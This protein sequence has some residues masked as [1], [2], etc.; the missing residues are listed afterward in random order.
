MLLIDSTTTR[1]KLTAAAWY[2]YMSDDKKTK[3]QI[4]MSPKIMAL[5]SELKEK[6]DAASNAEVIRNA[7][8]FY[9]GII[10]E[11]DSGSQLLIRNKQGEITTLWIG[12]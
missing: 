1:V 7:L 11:I 5:L 3:V 9:E 10:R 8:K 12:V 6:T 2:K 4:D